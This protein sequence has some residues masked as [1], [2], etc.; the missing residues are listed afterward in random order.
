MNY[1][2]QSFLQYGTREITSVLYRLHEKITDK[3]FWSEEE[4]RQADYCLV[5]IRELLQRQ[6]PPH[7]LFKNALADDQSFH[8][9]K[10]FKRGFNSKLFTITSPMT[11]KTWILKI[12]HRISPVVDFGDPSSFAYFKQQKQQLAHMRKK[13]TKYPL[14][15]NFLPEPQEVLWIEFP[16]N[17]CYY[18]TTVMLQPYLSVIPLKHITKKLTGIQRQQLLTELNAIKQLSDSLYFEDKLQLDLLGEGNLAIAESNGSYHF[19]LLDLGFGDLKT[20]LPI[21]HTVMHYAKL[22]TLLSIDNT[23]RKSK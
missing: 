21:T 17:T 11:E 1:T 10:P 4:L 9:I 15:P 12:G 18:N 20:P 19:V 22:Y 13:L 3:Y 2:F 6:N 14:L 23:L 8:T 16:T 5:Y 7:V